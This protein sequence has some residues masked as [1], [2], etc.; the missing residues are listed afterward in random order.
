MRIISR[1]KPR[2]FALSVVN[3]QQMNLCPGKSVGAIIKDDDRFL[4]LYRKKH[5]VGLAFVAGHIDSMTS[6]EIAI[7]TEIY[8]ETGLSVLEMKP[9][10]HEVIPGSCGR[11]DY[12]GHE[13]FVYEITKW[14]GIARLMEPDKH[15]FVRWLTWKE[16]E[17]YVK[18][19]EYDPVWFN[20][21]IYRI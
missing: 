17:E 1:L 6:P 15:E 16:I 19:H 2:D 14:D 4:C 10:L 5:P 11:G 8:E 13:W 21:I 9:V 12:D 20:Y 18:N 7:R 3:S